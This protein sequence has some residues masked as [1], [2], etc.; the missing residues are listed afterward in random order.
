M[1]LD[2]LGWGLIF[3]LAGGLI[4]GLAAGLESGSMASGMAPN[5]GIMRSAR[6]ALLIGMGAGLITGGTVGVGAVVINGLFIGLLD[7]LFYSL[8]A[9]LVVGLAFGGY[10]CLSHLAL[11]LVLWR[12]DALPLNLV[13]FLDA[14]VGR[15]LLRR[16]GSGYIFVHRLLL[17]Y[18]A[19]LPD[20]ADAPELGPSAG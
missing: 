17:E 18:F 14:C 6:H 10:A 13:A 3:G 12:R 5:Q 9:W 15:V 7:A 4:I 8:A 20:E 16:V 19:A 1:L 2:R 11:R